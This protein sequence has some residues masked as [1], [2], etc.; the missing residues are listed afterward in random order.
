[1]EVTYVGASKNAI[2]FVTE[3]V[4]FLYKAVMSFECQTYQTTEMKLFTS[5]F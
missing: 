1:M 5:Q 3:Y 2:V 4:F